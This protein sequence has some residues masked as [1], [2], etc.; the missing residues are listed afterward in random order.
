MFGVPFNSIVIFWIAITLAPPDTSQIVVKGP[1]ATWAW[2]K[3]AS[4][5][6]FSADRSVWTV[7]GE[8]VKVS[9]TTSGAKGSIKGGVAQPVQ[10]V[11][12]HDWKAS[13]TLNLPLSSLAKEGETY[14]YTFGKGTNAE[15][16]YV[17]RFRRH[18]AAAK[19]VVRLGYVG[20]TSG[21]KR[22]FADSGH[23][24]AF[25]R[26]EG[27]K[28]LSAIQIYASRYGYPQ[29][30]DEDFHVY[31]LDKDQKVL[32]EFSF[33]YSLI[34]RGPERWYTLE[35]PATEV[36]E[37]FHVALWFNAERTKGI[38]L[39][40]DKGVKESHSSVGLPGAGFEPVREKY[41]WMV[42]DG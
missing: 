10:G 21:D 9:F 7:E 1:D 2:T 36:P 14:V 28:Y 15:Q 23:A 42:R 29:P 35:L 11:K 6:G 12:G 31:V 17:I 24:I 5:W 13:P 34:A 37:R 3:Q 26:P 25:Y 19:G 33:P 18:P 8:N 22:S 38:Y 41:D 40:L 20:E 32:K 30:P 16:Q 39:G 27:A 4:G